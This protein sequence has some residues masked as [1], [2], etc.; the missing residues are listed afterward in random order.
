[1]NS[2]NQAS[3]LSVN[4]VLFCKLGAVVL[5]KLSEAVILAHLSRVSARRGTSVLEGILLTC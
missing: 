1:M 2:E 4:L 3:L 5:K